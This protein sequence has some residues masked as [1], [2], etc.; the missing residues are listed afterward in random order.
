MPFVSRT[1]Q[2]WRKRILHLRLFQCLKTLPHTLLE[3]E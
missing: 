3:Y 2:V 1:E